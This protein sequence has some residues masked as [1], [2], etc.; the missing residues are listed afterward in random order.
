MIGNDA[1]YQAGMNPNNT[2][3]GVKRLIG[4][5]FS[6]YNGPRGY[7]TLAFHSSRRGREYAFD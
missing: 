6:R 5:K 3:F 1:M 7:E 2:V 4:R